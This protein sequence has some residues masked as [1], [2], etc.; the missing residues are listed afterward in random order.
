MSSAAAFA[1][2]LRAP[3]FACPP[4]LTAWNGSDP[5]GRFAIYRNN[6]LVSLVDALADSYPV[7]RALHVARRFGDGRDREQTVGMKPFHQMRNLL[8]TR[9]DQGFHGHAVLPGRG[10]SKWWTVTPECRARYSA[11]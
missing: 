7:V 10:Y 3:T 1:A 11:I 5:A 6:H 8:K 4:G 2:A 9:D